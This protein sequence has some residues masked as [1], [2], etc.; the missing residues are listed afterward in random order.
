MRNAISISIGINYPQKAIL[1]D[2]HSS[3]YKDENQEGRD[4]HHYHRKAL[5]RLYLLNSKISDL[6]TY[7]M[8]DGHVLWYLARQ[9]WNVNWT[10]HRLGF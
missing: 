5:G 2:Y 6:K 7:H 9:G 1:G 8:R 3:F 4:Q 10:C